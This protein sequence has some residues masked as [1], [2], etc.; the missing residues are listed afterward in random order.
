MPLRRRRPEVLPPLLC[1]W[2]LDKTYLRT[3][4]ETLRQLI[5][6]ARERGA[7]KVE[8]PGVPAVMKAM[9]RIADAQERDFHA[10][11]ISASPPQI[12]HAVR[13][14]L[15][16]DG[17]P[18]DGITFKDQLQHIKRGKLK[19]LREHVGYKLGELFRGRLEA[20][21]GAVELLFGDDWESDALS[22]SLYADALAGVIDTERLASLL[23]RIG[24]DPLAIPSVTSLAEQA[25]GR[26]QVSRIFI[27][28]ERRTP[29]RT[30]R[31]YGP[32]VVPAFN[33]FQTAVVLAVDGYIASDDVAEVAHALRERAGFTPRRLANTLADAVRR[34]LVESEAAEQAV[35]SLR[36]TAL[37]PARTTARD[38]WVRR[39]VRRLRGGRRLAPQP[40]APPIDYD[41]ILD[42]RLAG[43]HALDDEARA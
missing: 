37:L 34:G 36:L 12:G 24:V 23:G 14:K 28:L 22:Y 41:V 15:A 25:R 38:G 3:E 20:P 16:L 4:F 39:L 19:N 11:F 43:P 35:E 8:V 29:L 27:N 6:T 30:F 18:Y 9:R 26:G 40:P 33:Y 17:V 31:I 5:R 21:E 2:D 32:R 13:E 1:R 7:D 10:Y 42:R